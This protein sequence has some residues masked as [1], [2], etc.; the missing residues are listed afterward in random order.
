MFVTRF[1]I[2]KNGNA[3]THGNCDVAGNLS[4][5]NIYNKTQVDILVSGKQNT[6]IF[7]DPTQIKSACSGLSIIRR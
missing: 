6:L 7:R 5:S 4:A 1:S 3:Y 2:N